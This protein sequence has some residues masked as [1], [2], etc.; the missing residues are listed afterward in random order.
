MG[1]EA[2]EEREESSAQSFWGVFPRKDGP[3]KID[4]IISLGWE[5]WK[6]FNRLWAVWVVSRCLRPGSG[7]IQGRRN[8]DLF[9]VSLIKEMM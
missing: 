5:S 8:T 4:I 1:K 3:G 9:C 2:E 6:E 7:V